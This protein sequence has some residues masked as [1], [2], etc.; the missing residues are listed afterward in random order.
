[1]QQDSC[2]VYDFGA[3]QFDATDRV[4]TRDGQTV[5]LTPKAADLLVALLDGGGR[6]VS[7]EDLIKKV[8]PDTF[9][10]DGS[11]AF[12]VN[13]LR[14]A[15]GETKGGPKYIETVPRRG[16]RFAMPVAKSTDV[17]P[18]GGLGEATPG[19]PREPS[20]HES[21]EASPAED[22]EL[23]D[24]TGIDVANETGP[25]RTVSR[26]GGILRR[27]PAAAAL[28][29]ALVALAGVLSLG[30][31][32]SPPPR[33][34]G[35]RQVTRDGRAKWA[36]WP[37]ISDGP[38]VIFFGPRGRQS[39]IAVSNGEE[40]RMPVAQHFRILDVSPT[41]SEYL[42]TRPDDHGAERALWSVPI[43]TGSPRR[44]G[45][46]TVEGPVAA[47]WSGDGRSIAFVQGKTLYVVNADG[48]DV[49]TLK[50]FSG[51]PFWVRWSPDGRSLRFT[52]LV[53]SDRTM[54]QTLWEINADGS[55]GRALPTGSTDV[56]N[57]CCGTWTP[58][59]NDFIFQSTRNGR[60]DLWSLHRT[61]T[62]VL[63]KLREELIQLTFGPIS[64][65][66][67][68]TSQDG[69]RIFALG[70][71]ERATQLVRYDSH[72]R[73]FTPYLGGVAASS[74]DVSRDGRWVTYVMHP[75]LTLWR[76]RMDGTERRQLT[77]ASMMVSGCS[78]SPDGTRIA[79]RGQLPG[80][81]AKI[82]LV[83][84]DGGAPKP[85]TSDDV[86]QG[87]P[88]WSPDGTQIAFGDVPEKFGQSTGSEAIHVYDLL[89]HTTTVLPGSKGLWTSRWSP[90]GRHVAAL[91]IQDQRLM[92][93]DFRTAT[94]RRFEVTDV[95]SPA[96]SRD[97]QYLH[98]DDRSSGSVLKR[99][100]VADGTVE[101]LVDLTDGPVRGVNDWSGVTPDGSPLIL[102]DGATQVYALEVERR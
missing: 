5:P 35:T 98:F 22:P 14:Q 36:S 3:F 72:A 24:T 86:Q 53:H 78:W 57:E 55:G 37:V 19:T 69:T 63:G 23:P 27:W 34:V 68:I 88:S 29:G 56:P 70:T 77:G 43:G 4:L 93:F 66:S 11:L 54:T 75:Q 41:R 89:K 15:L 59:G 87:I 101:T 10:E 40:L 44:L 96:W 102:R 90:D 48:S 32:T 30:W 60:T 9:V 46:V 95:S 18:S 38:R 39:A 91:T 94:W 58:D 8:W 6:V 65:F 79:I 99:L 76:E 85:L 51:A 61:R 71:D 7:K 42:A 64:F 47:S 100:R 28:G 17:H 49:R 20:V 16:Y 73:E 21:L 84:M 25:R 81:Q 82:Y 52:V 83:P 97:S 50:T 45:E 26:L 31:E 2:S 74:V 80:S 1:M 12:Q 92:L 13:Q 62:G 67:P 33:V